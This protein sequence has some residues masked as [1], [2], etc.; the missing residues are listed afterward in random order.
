M[1]ISTQIIEVLDALCEKFGVVVDWTASNVLPY[2]TDL[3]DRIVRYKIAISIFGI[4]V[5]V[6]ILIVAW[7]I[8]AR[9][10]NDDNVVCLSTVVLTAISLMC[11]M[12]CAITIIKANIIPEAV[13]MQYIAP[14][15]S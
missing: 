1:K 3:C 13:I 11:I 6:V 15:I 5:S 2:A 12:R 9:F 8:V 10:V 7:F 14:Y 4:V